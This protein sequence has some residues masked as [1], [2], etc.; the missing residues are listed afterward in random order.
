MLATGHLPIDKIK[1]QTEEGVDGRMVSEAQL[2]RHLDNPTKTAPEKPSS[3]PADSTAGSAEARNKLA[4]TDYEVYEALNLL[5][6][7]ALQKMR[8]AAAP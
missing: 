5:K 4:T 1:V 2:D 3:T 7:M 6:G 8:G